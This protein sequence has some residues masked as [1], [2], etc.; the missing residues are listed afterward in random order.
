MPIFS[1]NTK[2]LGAFKKPSLQQ[3]IKVL[4]SMQNFFS[5]R[6]NKSFVVYEFKKTQKK[7]TNLWKKMLNP[8]EQLFNVKR[9]SRKH[10]LS[11]SKL[12]NSLIHRKILS[13]ILQISIILGS[14][15]VSPPLFFRLRREKCKQLSQCFVHLLF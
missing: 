4:I 2:L 6:F 3:S 9:F 7:K 13:A 5:I 8:F 11:F 12:K 15:F 14:D 1:E 10:T